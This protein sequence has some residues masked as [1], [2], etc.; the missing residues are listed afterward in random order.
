M[1]ILQKQGRYAEALAAYDRL[2]AEV[3][4]NPLVHHNRA[5][6]LYNLGRYPEAAAELA[7]TRRLG[8]P[9]NPAFEQ[10]LQQHLP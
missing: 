2:L 9:V 6:A 8:G 10:Q 4:D 3:P 1:T 5:V 7:E